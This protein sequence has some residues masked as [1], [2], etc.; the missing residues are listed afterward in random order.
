MTEF[1]T[2]T[3][4]LTDFIE[5][6]PSC[7]HVI[8][9]ARQRLLQA[10]LTQL[11]EEE[12]WQLTP[13]R[14]YFVIRSGSSLIAFRLPAGEP[15]NFQLV[16]AHSDSPSFKLKENPELP[17]AGHYVELNVEK[18]GGMLCAPWFDRPLS[19]A[20][21]AV[22]N[23]EG[24]LQTRLVNFDR[25]LVMLPSL[26]IH[27][28][29][30]A[31][32]G[33]AYKVQSDMLPILGDETT[34]GQFA[35][36]LAEQLGTEPEN[37]L[38]SDLFLYARSPAAVW[39]AHREYFSAP[40]LDDL[41]CAFSALTAFLQGGNE[42]S[43]TA[44]CIFDNEEV[45]SST[46]QGADSTFLSDT[47]ERV[48]ACL[49][50]SREKHLRMVASGFMLSADNGHAVHPNHPDKADP[51]NRP[52][53]NGGVVVK[54]NAQQKYTTDAV[55]AAIFGQLCA[56]NKIPTQ[57]YVNHSDVA[58]GSTLGNISTAHVSLNTVDIGAAQLAMHSPYETGGIKD[59]LC[60]QQA[61]AAFY[62]THIS[63][64]PDGSYRLED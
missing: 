48:T 61:M 15:E 3:K 45:G 8:E 21:P 25:D 57:I 56:R 17:K 29:R 63:R 43:V 42:G 64:C 22:V 13:G 60:L 34:A 32:E 11:R 12:A 50:L 31:N 18:Y 20:G 6:C 19:I 41:Q 58:G 7:Y 51:V 59:T 10:G 38:A 23:E 46:R 36:M 49:G 24:R 62:R 1:E 16:A 40:R 44:C 33:T 37:I 35:G 30:Q 27:M 54:Y 47:L 9:E 2:V 4:E 55:S 26:A 28:N 52:C 14:G 5:K 39:G 53:L